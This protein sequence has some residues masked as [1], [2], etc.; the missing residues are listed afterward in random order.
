MRYCL[1]F[2]RADETYW[3]KSESR[4]EK[5]LFA[6]ILEETGLSRAEV[7][8]RLAVGGKI[9]VRDLEISGGEGPESCL[10]S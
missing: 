10:E 3:L 4:A 5:L 7:D 6:V 1:K 8:T 2:K 9:D